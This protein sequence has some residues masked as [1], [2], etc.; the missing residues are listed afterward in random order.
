L[1]KCLWR[2]AHAARFL[3]C[4]EALAGSYLDQVDW[5]A[6][7]DVEARAAAL[8][9]GLF[10]ARVDGKS[11]VEYLTADTDK[12]KVRRFAR[13]FLERPVPYLAE[14]REAWAAEIGRTQGGP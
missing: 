5:E 14:M 10:L 13:T 12:Q 3:A 8:L 2:P 6:R 9:P 7:A 1:L 4:F 11:P